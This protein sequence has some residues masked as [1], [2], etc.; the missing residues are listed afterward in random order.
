MATMLNFHPGIDHP[1]YRAIAPLPAAISS[2]ARPCFAYDLRNDT[3]HLPRLWFIAAST[4]LYE[5]NVLN[6]E[7]LQLATPALNGISAGTGMVFDPLGGPAGTITSAAST[8]QF[9]IN[10]AFPSAVGVNQL[11]NRGDGIGY[12]IRI[13]NC[14]AG[15]GQTEE[16][17]IVANSGGTQPV[18]TVSPA[19]SFTP[20]N[21]AR[22]EMLSGRV[23]LLS[24]T[25][26]LWRKFDVAC[27]YFASLSTTNML[28]PPAT[29]FAGC[30]LS[31]QYV[32]YSRKPG[33]GFVV[34]A[35]TYANG[36]L[37]CLL[38]TN[39]AAGTLTGQTAAGDYAITAN[40]FRNFQIRIVEDT[41]TPTA[42]GQRRRISSH[43]GGAATTPVYT[44]SA[45]WTVTPSTTCKYVIENPNDI[46]VFTGAAKVTYCYQGGFQADGAW[47]TSAADS[48]VAASAYAISP[49]RWA[50]RGNNI[51]VGVT[52]MPNWGT[53]PDLQEGVKQSLLYSCRGG[54]STAIDCLDIA[55]GS[56]GVWADTIVY[57]GLGLTWDVA[58]CSAYDG[59]TN[60]GRYH[61]LSRGT[62]QGYRFDVL[63]RV[64]EPFGYLPYA[65][66][67][68]VTGDKV[69]TWLYIDGTT[70][71]TFII[72]NR[73]SNT[74]M[75]ATQAQC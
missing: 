69:A 63:N 55:G 7:W 75:F 68:A 5:Y 20:A 31:E 53:V 73:E 65:Q 10:T 8:S 51:G 66:G 16:S 57:G 3:S 72:R 47:S 33:E 62:Q 44:I 21:S 27:N 42:V 4:L 39:S 38:A 29:D 56:V 15:G 34:G 67:T 46:F 58:S 9:T 70:K 41:S 45:N 30:C 37:N 2:A 22:Y 13:M 32:P 14:I 60:Q 43:T 18:I 26:V 50:D 54:A 28:A 64:L 61:Y 71:L 6:N 36:T 24:S 59:A 23:M 52:A 74:E 17:T 12:R 40:R 19:F 11:A 35:S 49:V 1:M 25:T 48:G